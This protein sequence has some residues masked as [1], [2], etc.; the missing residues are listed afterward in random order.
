MLEPNETHGVGLG[1]VFAGALGVV[2]LCD[3]R[4]SP[5]RGADVRPLGDI[6]VGRVV[7]DA[8]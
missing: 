3:D 7:A 6:A 5:V 4:E 8:E 1:V 2:P